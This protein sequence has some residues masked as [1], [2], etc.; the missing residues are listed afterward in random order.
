MG[1]KVF[2]SPS[3]N[4]GQKWD[5]QPQ[6]INPRDPLGIIIPGSPRGG[7]NKLGVRQVGIRVNRVAK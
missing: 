2:Y 1:K 6:N 4:P 5:Y 3:F 7:T